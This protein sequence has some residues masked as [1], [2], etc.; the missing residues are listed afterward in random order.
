MKA[1][2]KTWLD[3]K[4]YKSNGKGGHLTLITYNIK[5]VISK[6]KLPL[7]SNNC[8]SPTQP[9]PNYGSNIR[10]VITKVV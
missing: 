8:H 6:L 3:D 5:Y 2:E 7:M 9:K 4:F 1:G 10:E